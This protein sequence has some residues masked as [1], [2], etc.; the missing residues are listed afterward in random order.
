MRNSRLPLY[1]VLL[2]ALASCADTN[3]LYAPGAY[4]SGPF[5]DHVYDTWEKGTKEGASR[6]AYET[7]LENGEHGYF[8]GSGVFENPRDCYGFGQ[9][10]QFHPKWFL[11]DKGQELRWGMEVG[12]S[13][14]V[15]GKIGGYADNSPLY[16]VIYSQNKRLDRFYENFSHGYLSK[17]Y[18]GQIKCNGWSYYAMALL[19][20]A[21]FATVFPYELKSA[22]YFATSL[23]VATDKEE[24]GGRVVVTD[25]DFT[26]FKY[27]DDGD[28]QGYKVTLDD[29]PLSCNAGAAYTSLVGFTFAD[30]G[31]SPESIVGLAIQWRLVSEEE[32]ISNDF[33]AEGYHDGLAVYEILF[34][35]S[36]WY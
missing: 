11:N 22:E 35:D 3:Q 36:T 18:N 23:L 5:V 33:S 34:P 32:G 28:L 31:I 12:Y 26:F 20:D 7:V 8:A 25:I 6:L 16:D 10:K 13:D 24:G 19:S 1:G 30:A 21:G 4:L 14:I 27:A 2:V 17:L 29:V 9:A 15:P